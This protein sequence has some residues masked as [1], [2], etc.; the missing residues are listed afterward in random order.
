M[1]M[2]WY[3]SGYHTGFYVVRRGARGEQDG[4]GEGEGPP[5]D[6][7]LLCA[8]GSPRRPGRGCRAPP[9]ATAQ[10]E[11]APAQLGREVGLG[12]CLVPWAG[13]CSQI[14]TLPGGKQGQGGWNTPLPPPS[15]SPVSDPP[16]LDLP[17]TSGA[18]VGQHH[19]PA[20]PGVLAAGTRTAGSRCHRQLCIRAAVPSVPPSV[21]STVPS[22]GIKLFVRPA[23]QPVCAVPTGTLGCASAA[24][25][26]GTCRDEPHRSRVCSGN[27]QRGLCPAAG[28][29]GQSW[30]GLCARWLSGC[31]GGTWH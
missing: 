14:A 25:A 20:P 13:S 8:A 11:E 6:P 30:G 15:Y 12:T 18:A 4:W 29:G 31:S 10:G 19:A 24:P 5:G 22:F 1:L 23:C 7:P 28:L 3:M 16:Q 21:P 17:P 26:A 27:W 2:S 9:E